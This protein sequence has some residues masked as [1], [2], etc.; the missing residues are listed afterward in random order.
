[1]H[2]DIRQNL[3]GYMKHAWKQRAWRE[4]KDPGLYIRRVCFTVLEDG[5]ACAACLGEE[6]QRNSSIPLEQKI[7]KTTDGSDNCATS[8]D[9]WYD[10]IIMQSL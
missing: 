4:G 3:F 6:L 10:G 2:L 5:A 7:N 1:M 8:P 9:F